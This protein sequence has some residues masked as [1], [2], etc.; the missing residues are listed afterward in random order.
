MDNSEEKKS[1]FPSIE[2]YRI[3][4]ALSRTK[5]TVSFRATSELNRA[6]V[7]ITLSTGEAYRTSLKPYLDESFPRIT[8]ALKLVEHPHV[9]RLLDAG[10][11]QEMPFTV[12]PF[13]A[14]G[15]LKQ[16]TGIAR[17]WRDVFSILLP[18]AEALAYCHDHGIIHRDVRPQNIVINDQGDLCLTNFSLLTPSTSNKLS[19]TMTGSSECFPAYVAP[20]VWNGKVSPAI[21]QYSF[22]V[23]LYEM[24]TAT[25]PFDASNIVSLL[26]QQA[27]ESVT[28]PST[29]VGGVPK[30]VDALLEK[31]LAGDPAARFE[32]M[33]DLRDAMQVMLN[34]HGPTQKE[35]QRNKGSAKPQRSTTPIRSEKKP[36]PPSNNNQP[37]QLKK[38][39]DTPPKINLLKL[40]LPSVL[41]MGLLFLGLFLTR[42]FSVNPSATLPTT[43]LLPMV[44]LGL[45]FPLV[46]L[47]S[48]LSKKNK[49]KT[50]N[51][52]VIAMFG[53]LAAVILLATFF[54]VG[55]L[56]D[57][58]SIS[59]ILDKLTISIE[60]GSKSVS[61]D[62]NAIEATE[63]LIASVS[64]A[65]QPTNTPLP[66]VRYS[67]V[68]SSV[69]AATNT[70][71]YESS[72]PSALPIFRVP[73]NNNSQAGSKGST[74]IFPVAVET[75][76]RLGVKLQVLNAPF[77][78]GVVHVFK[79]S[80]VEFVEDSR[81]HINLLRGNV[82]VSTE[83][84]P[85]T[86]TSPLIPN[87]YISISAG[88]IL[89]KAG[90]IN[91]EVWCLEGEC[92][93]MRDGERVN[94]ILPMTQENFFNSDGYAE[95]ESTTQ[96][97]FS[98]IDELE[99][100]NLECDSCMN[101]KA[102]YL[103]N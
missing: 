101:V 79:S 14:A 31:T 71:Y 83:R 22:G 76:D 44:L 13:Y 68:V 23:M 80:E 25:L 93:I 100:F 56:T 55:L 57:K 18:I 91:I 92:E 81:P 9:I 5:S 86:I 61:A 19:V 58:I 95:R 28:P 29:L 82:F 16:F 1:K 45:G 84:S 49:D 90:R 2:G 70:E 54:L 46:K 50:S 65:I 36:A 87:E 32:S 103:P 72:M 47:V 15:S 51:A 48:T 102:L 6:S 74:F 7:Q 89:V 77:N 33:R 66:I 26:V 99:G 20:E 67:L 4:E 40:F 94:I 69:G 30:A 8:K 17:N 97:L 62:G 39:A 78:S 52:L 59:G 75:S 10:Y 60:S 43:A 41:M 11:T 88:Q 21:D 96:I 35:E 38:D 73:A 27:T 53:I 98:L 12:T 3:E 64:T 24:L 85:V 34:E 63:A 42:R 37:G